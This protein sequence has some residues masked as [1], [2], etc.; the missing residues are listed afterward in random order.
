MSS[1]G[2]ERTVEAL[3]FLSPDPVSAAELAEAIVNARSAAAITGEEDL[4]R[5]SGIGPRL[6]ERI[7]HNIAFD[8]GE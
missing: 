2:L 4:L 1:D 7:R 5:I 3:L 6:M 8:D